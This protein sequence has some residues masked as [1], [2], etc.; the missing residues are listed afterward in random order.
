MVL[1]HQPARAGWAAKLGHPWKGPYQVKEVA[2]NNTVLLQN[3]EVPE[4]DPFRVNVR[5]IKHFHL[6][7][8]SNLEVEA[9]SEGES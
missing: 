4:A 7:P 9:D 6:T 2:D 3:P 1:L 8:D 5:C